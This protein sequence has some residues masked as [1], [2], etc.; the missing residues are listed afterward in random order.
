MVSFAHGANDIGNSVGPFAAIY[1]TYNT[2]E[3]PEGGNMPTYYWML[4]LGAA[5][6]VIGL[7]TYGY[8]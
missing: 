8:K 7:W 2:W 5:G 6:I 4:C 3:V 1:Y